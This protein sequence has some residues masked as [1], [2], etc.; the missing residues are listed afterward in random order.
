MMPHH[1]VIESAELT[2]YDRA[3]ATGY[4]RLLDVVGAGAHWRDATDPIFGI[5][6]IFGI[7]SGIEE[8]LTR[9]I[10]DANLAHACCMASVVYKL[11]PAS[12]RQ[13][14]KT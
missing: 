10:F 1:L 5:F 14:A 6:G 13:D 12:S 2:D 9:Q 3:R 4:L 8:T 7:D 11:L